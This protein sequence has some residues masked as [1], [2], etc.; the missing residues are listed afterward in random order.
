MPVNCRAKASQQSCLTLQPRLS[1][2]CFQPGII[3][4]SSGTQQHA[5]RFPE[6][7][8]N[9]WDYIS[10]YT[11]NQPKRESKSSGM[12]EAAESSAVTCFCS[13]LSIS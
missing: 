7:Q 11:Y 12:K 2:S 5:H 9:D 8:I 13:D 6:P 3:L 4:T 10:Q 1:A